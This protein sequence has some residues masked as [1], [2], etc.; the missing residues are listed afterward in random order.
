MTIRC[1]PLTATVVLL[2]VCSSLASA[3]IAD[4]GAPQYTNSMF[5]DFITPT[6]RPGDDFQFA[7]DVTNPYD[8][9]GAVMTSMTLTMGIYMYATQEETRVVDEDFAD[10]PLIDGESTEKEVAIGPLHENQAV[11]V[12][13]WIETGKRTPDGS[14]FDQATYFVRL[15]LTFQFEGN[16]TAV[17]LQSRGYFTDEQWD[18]MVSFD[19]AESLVNT[20]Y[21]HS[22]GVDGLIPDSS[23]GIKVPIPLWPLGVLVAACCISAFG[24]LYYFVLDNPGRY[25]RLE[26]RF[27]ELR[28]KLGQLRDQLKHR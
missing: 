8:D 23:F 15:K 26:K 24:A 13:F 17:A 11:Q 22:L 27:Y 25:P 19:E 5:S 14:Y 7:F 28:G 9:P 2:M 4:P 20:T 6:V 1:G 18:T 3:D 12:T 10:P 21:M 16:D